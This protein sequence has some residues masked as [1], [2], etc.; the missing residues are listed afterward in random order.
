MADRG[1]IK[2]H[3]CGNSAFTDFNSITLPAGDFDDQD[4]IELLEG[5]IDHEVGHLKW[6][7]KEWTAK[8]HSQGKLFNEVRN[9]IEDVRMER[10]VSAEWPGARI[11]LERLVKQAIARGWFSFVSVD[12]DI[13][14]QLQAM[15]L[16]YCRYTFCEQVALQAHSESAITAFEQ[17]TSKELSSKLIGILNKVPSLL[18]NKCSYG[19]TNEIFN[20]LKDELD[21][22]QDNNEDD[23][24]ES[25]QGEPQSSQSDESGTGDNID[26]SDDNQGDSQNPQYSEEDDDDN[27]ESSESGNDQS[28]RG[29]PENDSTSNQ[30]NGEQATQDSDNSTEQSGESN[31]AAGLL[32]KLLSTTDFEEIPDLHEKV[33]GELENQANELQSGTEAGYFDEH[34][35][36]V[37]R[38]AVVGSFDANQAKRISA[39]LRRE[40]MRVVNDLDSQ[41]TRFSR[42]GNTID[43]NKLSG[44]PAGNFG[45]FRTDH[46]VRAPNCAFTILVDRSSSMGSE[47]RMEIA[48]GCTFALANALD[49]I[50]KVKTEVLYFNSS[51]EIHLAKSF[52]EK[53]SSSIPSFRVDAAGGTL[54]GKAL[55]KALQRIALRS[56]PKKVIILITDGQTYCNDVPVLKE[57][58]QNADLLNVTVLGIG[59]KT[60][61]LNGFEE[62]KFVNVTDISEL[63]N[64]LKRAV[65]QKLL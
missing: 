23:D 7:E 35:S 36:V 31:G 56:E 26:S 18:S 30:H 8:S 32:Q 16:Y 50:Q 51:P 52:T 42:S 20:L 10:A 34:P 60:D 63:K 25:N 61:H 33:R 65:K 44:I 46:I 12:S 3:I 5:A 37:V 49:G 54:T 53:A 29:E 40:L 11:N 14:T 59:I 55:D 9:A 17:S 19:L 43:A 15:V 1:D 27:L 38:E 13:A 6:T 39:P 24:S 62:H 28:K 45:V 2:I 64:E 4:Y 58:L 57:T 21:N 48:N 41:Q 47:S 22:S